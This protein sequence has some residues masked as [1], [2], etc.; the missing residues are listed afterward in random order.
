MRLKTINGDR[1]LEVCSRKVAVDCPDTKISDQKA[2]LVAK[3]FEASRIVTDICA[4]CLKVLKK[5]EH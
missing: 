5:E 4:K 2:E 3:L 1:V